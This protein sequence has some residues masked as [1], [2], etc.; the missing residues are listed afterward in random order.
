[1]W[2]LAEYGLN[3]CPTPLGQTLLT[4]SICSV[5]Q[6]TCDSGHCINIFRRCDDIQNCDDNSD[7]HN[8]E[9]VDVPDNYKKEPTN[10]KNGSISFIH[11][12]VRITKFNSIKKSGDLE[13]TLTIEMRWRD[14]RLT[15][16]NI[17]DEGQAKGGNEKDISTEKQNDIWLPLDS[18]VQKNAVIGDVIGEEESITFV[19]VI[20]ND[21]ATAPSTDRA[22]EGKLLIS[23]VF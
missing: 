22:I 23:E 2:I 17:M 20:V 21:N 7:E 4:F 8:C 14:R 19:R 5:D 1:M 13:I 10:Q 15:F 16:L 9:I 18:V 3:L 12:K 6:F 11:T